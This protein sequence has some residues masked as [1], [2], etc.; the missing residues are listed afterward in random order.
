MTVRPLVPSQI[1]AVSPERG[2]STRVWLAFGAVVAV[3]A[4]MAAGARPLL[5]VG[6][7]V[8]A[9]LLAL[10]AANMAFGLGVL[11]VAGFLEQFSEVAGVISIAKGIG[12][13]L[14]L[15]YVTTLVRAKTAERNERD[16]VVRH[17]ALA[18]AIVVFAAWAGTSALWADRSGTAISS[19]MRFA[20]NLALFP[21]AFAALRRRQHLPALM[22][23]F[24]V[25]AL[26]SVAYGLVAAS[27][28]SSPTVGRLSGAGL[29][30]NQLGGHLVVAIVFAVALGLIKGLPWFGRLLAFAAA[31][32][33]AAGLYLTESRGA[34]FFGFGSALIVTPFACG[35][36]RRLA[37][38]A[39][40]TLAVVATVSW[41]AFFASPA[42]LHRIT[43][44]E[45]AGGSGR[46]DLWTVGVRMAEAHPV[47]G[48]GAGNFNVNS[49]HYLFRPGLTQR[50]IYIVDR[51][52]VPHNI[53]LNV[54]TELGA[55]GLALFSFI[56]CTAAFCALKAAR[57]FERQRDTTM[58]I[59]A[60]ALFVALV[61][62]LANGFFS[63][64]VYY[65]ELW[66]LLA[67]GP[68]TFALA[69]RRASRPRGER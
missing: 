53:Y 33:C 44:P 52:L 65:K 47:W 56:V 2:I 6:A 3:L 8:G 61:A 26:G 17:P 19:A 48:V 30:P 50:D 23:V 9:G 29:N 4:G 42:A 10:V 54:L 27:D 15:A 60:R 37:A 66:L 18:T 39:M 69:R 43:H 62:L 58:E 24:V 51:P 34:L 36:G 31:A 20:L 49:V 35:R 14:A 7:T 32:G 59:L 40:T 5:V 21:I 57:L 11:V 55:I 28:P 67:L 63:S 45:A 68:A 38:G 41:F 64:G 22:T 16:L 12:A 13:I 46:K 25:A 1:A